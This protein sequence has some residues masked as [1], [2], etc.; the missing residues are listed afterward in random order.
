M[1]HHFQ[2][3]WDSALETTV[4]QT[5]EGHML[6]RAL[7]SSAERAQREHLAFAQSCEESQSLL[8]YVVVGTMSLP[9]LQTRAVPHICRE[10]SRD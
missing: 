7:E 9:N 2:S 1:L 3:P 6:W 8:L 4:P 5:R 10:K